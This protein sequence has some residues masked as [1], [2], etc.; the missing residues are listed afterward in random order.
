[1]GKEIW[2]VSCPTCRRRY[3]SSLLLRTGRDDFGVIDYPVQNGL[4]LG[5]RG[6]TVSDYWGWSRIRRLPHEAYEALFV[7]VRRVWNTYDFLRSVG[8]LEPGDYARAYPSKDD[9]V[10]AYGL[11]GVSV[12]YE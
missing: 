8:L 7:F 12:A 5:C 1:M 11:R 3:P 2:Y 10:E 9:F 4:S 6:F